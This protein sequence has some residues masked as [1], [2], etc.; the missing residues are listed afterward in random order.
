MRA[1]EEW[2]LELERDAPKRPGRPLSHGISRYVRGGCRC[3]V[4]RS[5]AEARNHRA[6]LSR[7]IS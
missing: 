2:Q 6:A 1:L 7:G 4:C 3:A 5:A